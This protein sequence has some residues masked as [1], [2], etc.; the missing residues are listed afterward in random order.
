MATFGMHNLFDFLERLLKGDR[1]IAYRSTLRGRDIRGLN[2]TEARHY[3]EA[4]IRQAAF[5]LAD[6]IAMTIDREHLY[7][8]HINAHQD[9]TEIE[10]SIVWMTRKELEAVLDGAARRVAATSPP[11]RRPPE[12][13][14]R[15]EKWPQQ[16]PP[17]PKPIPNTAMD[18][19]RKAI[20]DGLGPNGDEPKQLK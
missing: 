9:T 11:P 3:R 1:S 12:D 5:K 4:A 7:T 17:P 20:L 13:A 6:Y 18:K 14:A 2:A 16:P 10:V 8:E 19:L 15:Q